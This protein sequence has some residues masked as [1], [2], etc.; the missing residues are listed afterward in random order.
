MNRQH[1]SRTR[2]E[3]RKK[4]PGPMSWLQLDE[5]V[6]RFIAGQETYAKL[7]DERLRLSAYDVSEGI[8]IPKEF[9]ELSI[10]ELQRQKRLAPVGYRLMTMARA[11]ALAKQLNFQ[12]RDVLKA[13]PPSKV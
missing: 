8:R 12:V 6:Y 13:A 10:K 1:L 4:I 7:A 3:F 9:V 2:H 5:A 11:E